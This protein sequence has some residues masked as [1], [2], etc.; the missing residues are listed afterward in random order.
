MLDFALKLTL[1]P[2]AVSRED[3]E[4]LREVG[5]DDIGIH[6]IVQ[7][8]ALFSYYNRIAEGLGLSEEP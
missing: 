7:V 6:D 1:S 5:F 3:V 4:G 8:V 2:A